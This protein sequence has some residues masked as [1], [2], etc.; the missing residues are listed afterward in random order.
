[1]SRLSLPARSLRGRPASLRTFPD[2]AGYLLRKRL[3]WRVLLVIRPAISGVAP[4]FLPALRE[5][6]G[7]PAQ[8]D[9]GCEVRV[10]I[11]HNMP[12]LV[13]PSFGLGA[14]RENS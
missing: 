2:A 10:L 11:V 7:P 8:Q 14:G 5:G 12:A 13:Q 4:I 9:W 6:W 3:I 1:M